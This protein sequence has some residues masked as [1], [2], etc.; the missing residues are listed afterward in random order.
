MPDILAFMFLIFFQL[1]TSQ[2]YVTSV[3]NPYIN[4]C[5]SLQ[6]IPPSKT[7]ALYIKV[8]PKPVNLPKICKSQKLPKCHPNTAKAYFLPVPL[9]NPKAR[10][11]TPKTVV[12]TCP[13]SPVIQTIAAP[14]PL[15]PLTNIINSVL[16]E[17]KS[18]ITEQAGIL[19]AAP[20]PQ[21]LDIIP[22]MLQGKEISP[23]DI[24]K[25]EE[26]SGAPI[27]DIVSSV[28]PVDDIPVIKDKGELNTIPSK[29]L[30][31]IVPSVLPL[32]EIPVMKDKE[33]LTALPDVVPSVLPVKEL[34]VAKEVEGLTKVDKAKE[35]TDLV[36]GSKSV[37]SV[38]P[39][40]NK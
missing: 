2:Y 38:L 3:S 40:S 1:A 35:I 37:S 28:L 26:I 31:D 23:V 33:E 15:I 22:A 10:I 36:E 21:T 27:P 30:P 12:P 14:I 18:A 34:P 32:D 25:I 19:S 24:D 4:P 16:P 17:V 7:P 29:A 9:E 8:P 5:S 6:T 20:L 11:L 39:S 13:S